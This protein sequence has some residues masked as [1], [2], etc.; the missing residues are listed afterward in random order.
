[1]G[2]R[3]TNTCQYAARFVVKLPANDGALCMQSVAL[4]ALTDYSHVT[5]HYYRTLNFL[6]LKFTRLI[7]LGGSWNSRT[8]LF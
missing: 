2:I 1:M 8:K 4:N 3:R 7:S 5:I 6:R